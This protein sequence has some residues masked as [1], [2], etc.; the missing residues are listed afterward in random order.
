MSAATF[1]GTINKVADEAM[2]EVMNGLKEGYQE[3][4]AFLDDVERETLQEAS[5]TLSE[6]SRQAET[7]KRQ[8][9]GSAELKTRN[10]VLQLI[11]EGVEKV[12]SEAKK[13][14]EE[15]AAR[16]EYKTALKR[17]VEESLEM[18]G[19][20]E[21]IILGNSRDIPL[22]KKLADE[23]S[24]KKRVK[25]KVE[26]K[27]IKT[28]GGLKLSTPDG[29]VMYDNTFEARLERLRPVLRRDVAALFGR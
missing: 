2:R 12:F 23:I 18:I 3:A 29:T 24:K 13:R 11:E 14:L 21:L 20:E 27:P 19:A 5:R 16:E 6:K 7:L 25:L 9:I 10:M 8:V 26:G 4:M 22:L 17:L 28:C 15:M 1:E